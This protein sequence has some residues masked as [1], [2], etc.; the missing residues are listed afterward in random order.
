[1]IQLRKAVFPNGTVSSDIREKFLGL[2]IRTKGHS[3]RLTPANV[4]AW[5]Q[6]CSALAGSW[7]LIVKEY[8]EYTASSM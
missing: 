4:L 6:T 7:L 1:M 8:G 2:V 5:S 3:S